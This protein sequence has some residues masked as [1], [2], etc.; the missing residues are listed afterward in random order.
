MLL[1]DLQQGRVKYDNEIKSEISRSKPYR[2]WL[3]E[4]RIELRGLFQVPEISPNDA[5]AIRRCQKTFGITHEE[6]TRVIA[7]MAKEGKEP[8]SS[9]GNDEA[10]AIL[11]GRPTLLFDYFKQ[12]FA[13]VTNPPIDPYRESLVMSLMSFIGK[14]GNLLTESAEHCHQLKLQHPI[15]SNDDIRRLKAIDLHGMSS[16]VINAVYPAESG[17][18]G[19]EAALER[20]SAEAIEK[21]TEGYTFIILSD[22]AIDEENAPIPSLLAVSA[23][24]HALVDAK[25]R[26]ITGLFVETGEARDVMHLALLL[27]FGVSAI[28]PY[29]VFESLPL[30]Q[31][32]GAIDADMKLEN[33]A[34][35]YIKAC[36]TGILKIMSKMGVSTLRSYRGSQLFEAI[37]LESSF[38]EKYFTG[39]VSRIGGIGLEKIAADTLERHERVFADSPE[40]NPGIVP[41]GGR[42]H[43]RKFSEKH[44][45]TAEAVV[46]MQRAARNNDAEAYRRFSADINNTS[47]KLCTLRSLFSFHSA[48]AI[49]I[50]EV[51]PASEIVK[52]FVSSAMSLGSISREAHETIAIAMNRLG[53]MSNSG[54]GGENVERYTLLENGD[55]LNSK[56]KQIASARF[57][58][59][60][61][62][63]SK[64]QELQIKI[65]QGAKP[66]KAGSCRVTRLISS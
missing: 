22:R 48:E 51:E 34:E 50:D 35:N 62:Y 18:A 56:V 52:R 38:V 43:Y 16:A 11:S 29:L 12:L 10:L 17:G 24:H 61:N 3:D 57:G 30:L 40:S 1:V 7:P 15:L 8:L 6:L 21:A 5:A 2:R 4:N 14:E 32:E 20:I 66:A 41:S 26:Q 13:Q 64:A 58:V 47:E 27:G 28:N 44:L 9:M 31:E 59:T 39:T 65:A 23:V 33:A 19:L 54:E 60:S 55:S 36:K 46:N 42:I 53:G 49:D 45:M 63:L 37:G 25:L